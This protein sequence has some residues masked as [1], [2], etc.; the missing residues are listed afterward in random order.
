MNV[1]KL[2]QANIGITL[3]ALVVTIVIL[4][5]LAGITINLV[6]SDNGIIKKAQIAKNEVE[7]STIKEALE[8][9]YLQQY[10][11]TKED[12]PIGEQFPSTQITDSNTLEAIVQ[13]Q[14]DAESVEQI[15]FERLYYLDMD[16][17]G[18]FGITNEYFMDIETRVVYINNG[19]ELNSG[20]TYVLEEKEI[21]PV[22]LAV[23]Q[24]VNGFKL[25]ATSDEN[26]EQIS[27]Y[28]FY[29]NNE[30]YK[31]V[32]TSEKT[33]QIEVTDKEF[34]N[35]PCYVR[36]NRNNGQNDKSLEV[37]AENY[38][39]RN[40]TD[41]ELF[42]D[43]VNNGNSYSGKTI[44]LLS[45][46]D[47]QGSESS[48]WTPIGTTETIFSGTFQG[49]G[50]QV[51][52]LYINNNQPNQGLFGVSSGHILDL[53]LY[54]SIASTE[55]NI[56]GIVGSNSGTIETCTNH[57]NITGNYYVGG[58]SGQTNNGNVINC[59]NTGNITGLST[60][61]EN[62][63]RVGGI[64]GY[65]LGTGQIETCT[66]AGNINGQTQ[67]GGIVGGNDGNILECTNNGI[68]SGT[69]EF[70]GGIVGTTGSGTLTRCDNYGKVIGIE[71]VG[72]IS[73]VQGVESKGGSFITKCSNKA[74]IT[75]EYV[76]GG[77]SGF[78]SSSSSISLAYNIGNVTATLRKF[79]ENSNYISQVG[80]ITGA[81]EDGNGYIDSCYNTGIIKCSSLDAKQTGGIIGGNNGNISNCYNV[82]R[83]DG[84]IEVG[85][86]IGTSIRMRHYSI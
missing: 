29:I 59:S 63:S 74:D 65:K 49:N 9:Y 54:G 17:L 23:E 40:K 44:K 77:I 11:T 39:I 52:N 10:F 4:L 20:M 16:R 73:G 68:V 5:I 22:T 66:N 7:V 78:T 76:V 41:M 80:G 12:N 81:K 86:I 43:S 60:D 15:H 75:G 38:F 25:I 56:G 31:T 32:V 64:V 28:N 61:S 45:D 30:L 70:T 58:I 1:K 72:G 71:S 19:I 26:N 34:G 84:Q 36:V 42:R 21:F 53:N 47:L 14:S 69:V 79:I 3:I 37:I 83:V 8:L 82:G 13:F 24:I 48:Q 33:A 57:S 18:L 85:G 2:K 62:L 27:S 67:V 46:I 50:H 55:E 51:N 6:F 35:L